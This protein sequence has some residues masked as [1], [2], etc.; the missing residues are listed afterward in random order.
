MAN[1][2]AYSGLRQGEEFALTIGQIAPGQRVIHVNRKV[3]EVAGKQ[4]VELPKGRKRRTTIY[5][6]TTPSGYPLAEKIS[7]RIEQVQAEMQAGR[8]PRGLTFPSHP[9]PALG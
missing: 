7:A 3:I 9:D 5:P 8:N 2:G 4:H 1:T 6:V